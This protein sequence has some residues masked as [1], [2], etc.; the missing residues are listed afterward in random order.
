MGPGLSHGALTRPACVRSRV[1]FQSRWGG[2]VK[3]TSTSDSYRGHICKTFLDT[4]VSK[5]IA[6]GY[7]KKLPIE[8]HP[9]DITD[10]ESNNKN[11]ATTVKNTQG[12][13][14]H[15]SN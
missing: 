8:N 4:Q 6:E 10:V 14:K 1:Q 13:K 3:E 15:H 7:E 9:Q 11:F 12:L 2:D 5:K